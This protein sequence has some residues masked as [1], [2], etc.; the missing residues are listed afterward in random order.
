MENEQTIKTKQKEFQV[1][2]S[3]AEARQLRHKGYMIED[4][5]PNNEN[6]TASVFIFRNNS[7]FQHCWAEIK[8][9][10]KLKKFSMVNN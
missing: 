3:P 7:E 1:V 8:K 10:R 2:K 5:K 6:K 4:I 9:N